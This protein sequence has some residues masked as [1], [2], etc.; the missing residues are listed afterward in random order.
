VGAL[1]V[2]F[3]LGGCSDDGGEAAN[4][5]LAQRRAEVADR[6]AE[7]MPFDL[8]ATT[9][10]FTPTDGGGVQVVTADDPDDAEQVE[11]IR[12]HL[13]H[14][15]EQFQL[16]H[17]DDPAAIHGHNMPGLEALQAGYADVT[18]TYAESEAGATITYETDDLGL[19]EAIHDW[20]AAQVHD[21]GDHAE[22]D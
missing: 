7:V 12:E 10:A 18:V 15:A 5:S 11:L 8:D 22:M 2:S 1:L 20:F 6:G 13:A 19:I 21:H 17:F 14:E 9:H 3:V 16:G 4:D